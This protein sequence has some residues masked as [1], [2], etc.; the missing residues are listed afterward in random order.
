MRVRLAWAR[1]ARKACTWLR[2]CQPGEEI[3]KWILK[4]PCGRGFRREQCSAGQELCEIS[5]GACFRVAVI[6]ARL[7]L[8]SPLLR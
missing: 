2:A 8:S 1:S 4:S 6:A 7:R 5:L 3:E